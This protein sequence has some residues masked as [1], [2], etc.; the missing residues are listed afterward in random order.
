MMQFLWAWS[1]SFHPASSFIALK[2]N[3]FSYEKIV[4]IKALLEMIVK[5][6]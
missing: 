3:D 4:K 5:A 1:P 2:K 6:Q